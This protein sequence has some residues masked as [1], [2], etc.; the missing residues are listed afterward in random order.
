L[1]DTVHQAATCADTRTRT[2]PEVDASQLRLDGYHLEPYRA[3]Q[4]AIGGGAV[5][6]DT[7]AREDMR[8]SVQLR[9]SLLARD[10]A[11]YGMTTGFGDSVQR[12]VAPQDAATLQHNLVLG[13]LCGTGTPA[14]PAVV[15]ATMLS[16]A[17]CLAR[18]HSGIR[19]KVIDLLLNMITH[20]LVPVVPSRGSLGASGDLV[21]LAYVAAALLGDGEIEHKSTRYPASTALSAAGLTPLTLQPREGLAL[22]NGTSFATGYAS[23]A[24][25]EARI[26]ADTAAAA[27]ALASLALDGNSDHFDERLQRHKNHQGQQHAARAIRATLLQSPYS[28]SGPL[29]DPYSLRCAP[30]VIGVLYD[31]LAWGESWIGE[32][33][34]SSSDN[35]L[36]EPETAVVLH[37][38][39]FYAGHVG[40]TMEALKLAVANVADLLDRQVQ[41]L[42][43]EKFNR[44]LTP[45]LAGAHPDTSDGS[46]VHHGFKASQ[47]ACS[48]VTAETLQAA[49]P[50]MVFSR[51][52]E[53]HNQ[54]K[55]SM[56][57]TAARQATEVLHGARRVLAI[58]L[59]AAC[60]ALDLRGTNLG[61]PAAE[62]HAR[63]RRHVEALNEDRRL[64]RDTD[65][66]V[67]LIDNGVLA[68][69]PLAVHAGA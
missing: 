21:P 53:A 33:L 49:A 40:Q 45:N 25:T 26:L 22:I 3:A 44:G 60:Q 47:I 2:E 64:D 13:H 51:S 8:R 5:E 7:R 55:I 10:E 66:V 28:G 17:N 62:L 41:L 6:L 46:P 56:G 14:P 9:E 57:T 36:L 35:P 12:R 20:D 54:D 39:N 18:G 24:L 23:I 58:Q 1:P 52:S 16:R 42:V 61:T 50:A 15:R 65:T 32:E 69:P 31:T 48:A 34:N 38:G 29:Q 63:V 59:M 43:D 37:G 19:P 30:Q 11:V 68:A 27:T 4:I 67:S